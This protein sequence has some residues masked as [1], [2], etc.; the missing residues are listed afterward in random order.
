MKHLKYLNY[1]IRHKWFVLLAGLKFK[2]PLWRLIIHDWSKFLP[3]EWFPYAESFYGGY[4]KERPQHVKD[5]FDAA[6]NHHQKHNKHHFQYWV[7]IEDSGAAKPLEIPEKYL[8]EMAADWGGA[9]R[10]ITSKWEVWDYY[11]KVKD[12]TLL[13]PKTRQRFEELLLNTRLD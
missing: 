3:Y 4:G 12:K 10:A 6:W 1:L 5:T 13:H 8:R 2:A 11:Q 7:L 9:G